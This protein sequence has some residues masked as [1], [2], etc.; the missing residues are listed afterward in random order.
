MARE[1]VGAA[2]LAIACA[3]PAMAAPPAQPGSDKPTFRVD[4]T[5]PVRCARGATCA[6]KL[7]LT[8]LDGY[9]VNVDY[10]FKF[11]ADASPQ[12]TLEGTGTF[13]STGKQTGTLTVKFRPA[14]SG[15]V[16]VAGTFKLSVC[17]DDVCK[18]EKPKVTVD[19]TVK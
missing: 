2:L 14:A 10:P 19:V 11:V 15:K 7:G 17:T 18:I 9:K 1:L 4:I 16:R 5:P 6:L 8:A 3:G 13:A 12:V